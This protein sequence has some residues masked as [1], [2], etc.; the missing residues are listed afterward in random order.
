MKN[1]KMNND[2]IL[3]KRQEHVNSVVAGQYVGIA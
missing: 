1:F 2:K 3:G